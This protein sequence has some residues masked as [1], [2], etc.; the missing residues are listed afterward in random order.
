MDYRRYAR[1]EIDLGAIAHN[2]RGLKGLTR[3][4]TLFMAVVKADAYGHGVVPVARTVLASGADRLAVATVEEAVELREAGIDSLLH[5]L[6]EPPPSA[7]D[8]LV[9]HDVVTTVT[10]RP[11]AVALGRAAASAGTE[12]RFHLKVDT[13]MNRIGVRAEEAAEFA[14]GLKEFPGLR[15]EGTFTHFATADVPGDWDFERQLER[16]AIALE[17][18]GTEGVDPGIVHS[19]NS[20]ATIL[21]PETHMDMVRC[22]I[23]LYGLHPSQPTY[24]RIDLRPAMSVR[25]QVSFVKHVG[26]GEGVSYGMT[27]RAAAPVAIATIP[28]GY[29]DGLHRAASNK[30]EVLI[31]GVRCPQIGRITMDQVMIETPRDLNVTPGEDVVIVGEQG[32]VTLTMDDY[33]E[34]AGTINYE[35][36]C[37][38]GMRMGRAYRRSH[39]SEDTSA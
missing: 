23:A 9:D 4:G 15:H 30:L 19:A 25:A 22:G 20:A 14:A 24:G 8:L 3:P 38:F 28:L 35:T 33:A 13:G 29:A 10:S 39:Y 31:K 7:A 21:H 36:A 18:M 12:A 27:Y 32:G 37:A 2:V 17:Q 11:F 34:Q 1:G 5:I 16:F 6:S 26:M